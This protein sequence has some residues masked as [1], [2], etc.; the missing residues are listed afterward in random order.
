MRCTGGFASSGYFSQ[1][2]CDVL[3]RLSHDRRS[4]LTRRELEF[5]RPFAFE[6]KAVF[7][8]YVIKGTRASF[9]FR[10]YAFQGSPYIR[11]ILIV[12]PPSAPFNQFFI[13]EARSLSRSEDFVP[14]L[15]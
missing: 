6:R 1:H 9:A 7:R 14:L 8:G 15:A 10:G 11:S 12:M 13:R 3:G 4:M 2:G 5:Y